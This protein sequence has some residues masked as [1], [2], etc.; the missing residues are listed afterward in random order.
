MTLYK[1]FISDKMPKTDLDEI[2]PE[3]ASEDFRKMIKEDI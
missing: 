3:K 1:Y 2:D